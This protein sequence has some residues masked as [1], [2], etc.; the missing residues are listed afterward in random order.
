MRHSSSN[1]SFSWM[2]SWSVTVRRTI[3]WSDG[4]L[5]LAAGGE[6]MVFAEFGCSLMLFRDTFRLRTW[7]VGDTSRSRT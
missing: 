3:G 1:M 2:A 6:V 7:F 4:G 5:G